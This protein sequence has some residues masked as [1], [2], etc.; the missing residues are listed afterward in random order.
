[1]ASSLVDFI[2][3]GPQT[4]L[5]TPPKPT[6]GQL[7]VLCTW[8][9]AARKHISKYT[10]MYRCIAPGAR[11][12]LIESS[13]GSLT[14]AFFRRRRGIEFAPAAAAVLATLAECQRQS[15][16]HPKESSNGR[17]DDEKTSLRIRQSTLPSRQPQPKILL[18]IFSN[19]GMNSAT[20][21]LHVLRSRMNE[22]LTLTG[23]LF[24]SCPGNGTSYWFVYVGVISQLRPRPESQK[25]FREQKGPFPPKTSFITHALGLKNQC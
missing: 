16:L 25:M 1:M 2:V 3:I 9:G 18:H 15:P 12:L 21:L 22:P 6:S 13:I 24:D 23:M 10:A 17:L 7:I 20:H 5:H 4:C 8:L 14:S 19:G 11:I